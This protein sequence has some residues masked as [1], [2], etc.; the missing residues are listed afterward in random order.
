MRKK[1]STKVTLA[2]DLGAGGSATKNLKL[3]R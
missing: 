3:K 2:V 1:K